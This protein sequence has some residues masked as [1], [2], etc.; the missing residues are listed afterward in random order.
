M[1]GNNPGYVTTEEFERYKRFHKEQFENLALQIVDI[2]KLLENLQPPPIIAA[3][4]KNLLT[5]QVDTMFRDIQF[6]HSELN[7]LKKV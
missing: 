4:T 3:Q 1:A 6:L 5:K 7:K 2:R